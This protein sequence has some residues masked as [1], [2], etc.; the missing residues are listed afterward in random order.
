MSKSIDEL[1]DDLIEQLAS[2]S[3]NEA[4]RIKDRIRDLKQLQTEHKST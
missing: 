1:V 2:A 4:V 3:D